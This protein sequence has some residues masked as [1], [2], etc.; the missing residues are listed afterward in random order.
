[1]G[2][3]KFV[4]PFGKIEGLVKVDPRE[5][6]Q[7]RRRLDKVKQER[8]SAAVAAALDNLRE[9]AA[10]TENTMPAFIRCA[11]SYATIGE[12]CDTLRGVFGVQREFL[13]F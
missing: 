6:E 11:E 1:V 10:G 9:V 5:A 8:D 4:A 3:N 13:I 12:I 2:V 7:Q